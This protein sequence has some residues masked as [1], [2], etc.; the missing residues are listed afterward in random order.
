M[1]FKLCS[2]LFLFALLG[3]HYSSHQHTDTWLADLRAFATALAED[4]VRR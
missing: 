3:D 4:P 2:C 1:I